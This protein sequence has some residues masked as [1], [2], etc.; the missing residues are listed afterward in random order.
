M[1]PLITWVLL[2]C[3]SLLEATSSLRSPLADALWPR[4]QKLQQKTSHGGA[5]TLYNDWIIAYDTTNY[6]DTFA[7]TEL[8]NFL[9]EKTNQ[10]LS[11][12]LVSL[13]QHTPVCKVLI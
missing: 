10:S 2:S 4:P 7:A 1:F 9:L 8:R 11:L 5:A 6:N 3:S 13:E 12:P